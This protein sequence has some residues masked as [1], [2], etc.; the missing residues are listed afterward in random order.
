MKGNTLYKAVIFDFDGL[1]VD[2]EPIYVNSNKR[3]LS[4]KGISDFSII[5][6]IFGMRAEETFE[7]MKKEFNFLESIEELMNKRNSY[8]FDDFASGKLN[9]MTGLHELIDFLRLNNYKTA[10]GSSSKGNLLMSAMNVHDLHKYFDI[11]VCGDDVSKGKPEPDIY[12]RVAEILNIQPDECIVLEDAP[13]GVLAGK[14]A[15]MFTISIP[16][17]ETKNLNF[18]QHDLKVN[19]LFEVIDVI[20][21]FENK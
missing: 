2:S 7:L 18:P 12:L 10:I 1:V 20:K 16:N 21:R 5:D 3:F 6:R 11:I 19:N 9:L 8:I 14:R 13:N 15:G 4:E 17:H